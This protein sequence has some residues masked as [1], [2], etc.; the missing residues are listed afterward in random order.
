MVVQ[1]FRGHADAQRDILAG[2][3][4][5]WLIGNFDQEAETRAPAAT[6]R[7]DQAH[8]LL[9]LEVACSHKGGAYRQDVS[10]Q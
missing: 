3:F 9:R 2:L 5:F 1:G 4:L 10:I 8:P 6:R 7:A